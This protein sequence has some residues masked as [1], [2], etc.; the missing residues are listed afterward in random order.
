M[1]QFQDRIRFFFIENTK[2]TYSS[3][4]HWWE[5]GKAI[6]FLKIETLKKIL[7]FQD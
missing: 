1:L 3:T 5:K 2:N 6:N 4:R 7:E